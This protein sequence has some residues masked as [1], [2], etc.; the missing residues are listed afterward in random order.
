MRSDW[1]LV[2]AWASRRSEQ[3]FAEIVH[4]HGGMV[5][6]CCLRILGDRHAA[7]DAAQAAFM[8][9]A[10]KARSLRRGIKLAS[11]LYGAARRAALM[12][13]RGSARRARREKEAAM[14][15]AH[16]AR[17][18]ARAGTAAVTE[19]LDGELSRLPH[20]QQQAVILRYLEGRSEA[21]AATIAGCP[22][23]TLSARAA[24]GLERLRS[25]L[26]QR[27]ASLGAAALA[28][29]LAA[30][31]AAP[32]PESLLHSL[33]AVPRLAAGGAGAGNAGG[34][35]A[36][37]AK[38]VVKAMFWTKVKIATA[39]VCLAAAGVG[40]PAAYRALAAAPAGNGGKQAKDTALGRLA[41]SLKPGEM[42][43]LK[44][45]GL[46]GELTKSWYD[47]DHDAKG[48]RVYG[49][50]KMFHIMT[51]G[52]ANDA[53]WDPQT[54][55][56]FFLGGGHYAA[57]KFVTYSAKTNKWTLE[58]VPPWLDPR[59]KSQDCGRWP[60]TKAGNKSWPRGHS[61]DCNAIYPG[62]RRYALTLWGKLRLYDVD[63][64]KWLKS[65][66]GFNTN[67]KGPC[68]GFPELGGFVAF[69]RSRKLIVCDPDKGSKRELG[70]V[71]YGMH[72]V[73]EYN[74]VHKVLVVGGGDSGK[75]GT[76][77]LALVDAK[78]KIKRL[79]DLPVRV[80]CTPS[81]KLMC[82]PVSGEYIFQEKHQRKVKRKQKVY[83]L[84]PIL[85][86]WKEMEGRRFPNGIAVAVDT[87]GV[88]VICT[89]RQVFVY[90]HKPLWPDDLPGKGGS[91]QRS[92]ASLPQ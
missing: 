25:R 80:N 32:L 8:V 1:E 16:G 9:L 64:K 22:Q 75:N 56:I 74:P 5:Y 12:S 14:I 47:W 34:N 85:N 61:Y 92:A 11:W 53:K 28:G 24:R 55:Q 57:F 26:A 68:E 48:T 19:H 30:Q 69:S 91:K 70:R 49:A 43:E 36:A 41:A 2:R 87:Y 82:D 6:A 90:K 60:K 31:A 23:G 13:A 15:K 3:A 77:G 7:E 88:I 54:G 29:Q 10:G 58:P 63:K 33:L 37:L 21:E 67:S 17:K 38:G 71:P 46:N 72:G 73:M 62:K 44:T 66:P 20:R 78:G 18:G 42:Q 79:K 45:I 86:E 39:V 51:G 84:H 83:A 52:W 76:R 65:I 35:A 89:D 40:T 59:S 27:G 4:R 50:Q 81:S